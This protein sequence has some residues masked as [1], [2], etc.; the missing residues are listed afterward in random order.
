MY[1]LKQLYT[2]HPGTYNVLR[3]TSSYFHVQPHNT[4]PKCL[5]VIVENKLFPGSC[6]T[7]STCKHTMYYKLDD[8]WYGNERGLCVGLRSPPPT[9]NITADNQHHWYRANRVFF[10]NMPDSWSCSDLSNNIIILNIT[11]TFTAY[12]IAQ[13]ADWPRYNIENDHTS[14]DT[15]QIEIKDNKIYIRTY[16]EQNLLEPLASSQN[17]TQVFMNL[18]LQCTTKENIDAAVQC[19]YGSNKR[20]I[21]TTNTIDECGILHEHTAQPVL[22]LLDT[23][24]VFSI[25]GATFIKQTV[26]WLLFTL[27]DFIEI[28]IDYVLNLFSDIIKDINGKYRLAEYTILTILIQ[29]RT[30][31]YSRTLTL[32]LILITVFGISRH[33][34]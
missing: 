1:T 10:T 22:H 24:F 28:A 14:F 30:S 20:L 4:H 27:L 26:H 34:A 6:T 5:E 21:T 3:P 13:I 9:A 15:Q 7:H 31:D 18:P 16:Q 11:G 19:T 17:L 33:Y 23:N 8:T 25:P 32:I 12:S 29:T 2:T